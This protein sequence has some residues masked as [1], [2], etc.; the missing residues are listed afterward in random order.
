MTSKNEELQRTLKE[1]TQEL[2]DLQTS[3]ESSKSDSSQSVQLLREKEERVKEIQA[4]LDKVCCHIE[5]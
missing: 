1:T 4:E 3:L 5:S 2:M